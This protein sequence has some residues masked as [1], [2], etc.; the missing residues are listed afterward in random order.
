MVLDNWT[1]TSIKETMKVDTHLIPL[2]KRNQKWIRDIN[3][4]YQ[5]Y[6]SP[7]DNIGGNID[8]LACAYTL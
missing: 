3:V 4:K 8:D 1:T 5:N 2:T 6:K 7:G